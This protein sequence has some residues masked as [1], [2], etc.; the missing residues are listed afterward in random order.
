MNECDYHCALCPNKCTLLKGHNGFC[1]CG[2][3]DDF[4]HPTQECNEECKF[5]Y[6]KCIRLGEHRTHTCEDHQDRQKEDDDLGDLDEH[7]FW[8]AILT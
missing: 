5:C 7:P 8:R 3:H 4:R 6:E 2:G 1:N